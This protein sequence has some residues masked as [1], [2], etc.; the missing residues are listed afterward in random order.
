M[1]IK[2]SQPEGERIMPETKFFEFSAL[3]VDPRVGIS[4]L[5]RRPMFDYFSY[6]FHLKLLFIIVISFIYDTQRPFPNVFGVFVV[7]Q[8]F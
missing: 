5:H 8:N 3:S 1:Q 2:K 4:R 6:L 7:V